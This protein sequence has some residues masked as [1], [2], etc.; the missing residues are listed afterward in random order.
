MSVAFAFPSDRRL[1]WGPAL[2][3]SCLL[4]GSTERV[5][6]CSAY[7]HSFAPLLKLPLPFCFS[8]LSCREERR[9]RANQTSAWG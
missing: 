8:L 4:L 9:L 3:D 5:P 7:T 6:H 1:C 2:L